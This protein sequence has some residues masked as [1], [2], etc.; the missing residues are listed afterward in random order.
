MFP[1][2]QKWIGNS[3]AADPIPSECQSLVYPKYFFN[4]L[5][6]HWYLFPLHLKGPNCVLASL[7]ICFMNTVKS[8]SKGMQYIKSE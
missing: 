5:Q 4:N 6:E 3:V 1:M 8:P 7:M 2:C